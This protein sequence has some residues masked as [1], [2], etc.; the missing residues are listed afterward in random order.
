MMIKNEGEMVLMS[1]GLKENC[2]HD[3]GVICRFSV[4]I[5]DLMG[6]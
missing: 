3:L 6:I 2:F 4:I 5:L 1:V